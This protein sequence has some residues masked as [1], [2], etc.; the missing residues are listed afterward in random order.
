ME[1]I[2]K[3]YDNQGGRTVAVIG[4]GPAGLMAAEAATGSGLEIYV[5]DSMPS[6]G[7]KFLKAGKGGLNITHSEPLEIFLS[8]YISG[9][10]YLEPVLRSF[11]P[12]Q[13]MEWMRGLGFEP[14]KGSSGRI[15]P[16][17]MKARPLLKAWLARLRS[18]GVR[19]FQKHRWLGWDD[20]GRLIFRHNE[21]TVHVFHDAVILALGGGS[22]KNLGSGA[23]WI[24]ILEEKEI[25]VSSLKPSNCGF[26]CNWSDFFKDGFEGQILKNI[27]IFFD[28]GSLRSARGDLSVTSTGLEGGPLYSLSSFMINMIE[29][30]GQAFIFMDLSPGKTLEALKTELSK[31]RGSSSM[32]NHLRKRAGIYGAKA[33]ILR[34]FTAKEDFS[35]PARLAAKIKA[36][37]VKIAS[38]RPIDEAISTSGGVRFEAHDSNLMV[39]KIPGLFCAGEM[40][41]WD[42]PTGGYLL[43][44][45]LATGRA[46]GEG[47]VSWIKSQK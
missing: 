30:K 3:A 47:A 15:F 2:K 1:S 22:W 21:E 33:G 17:D 42:A 11:G 13:I 12:A 41:D 40:L 24:S 19:F 5:Y 10:E 45:C 31:P 20:E 32:S 16:S 9:R 28:D 39:K 23:S 29:E 26:N 34:E 4:A 14:F 43:T 46:A 36:L 18:S 8:R 27:S 38:P 6:P 44:A 37:P 25:P 7:L 35:D